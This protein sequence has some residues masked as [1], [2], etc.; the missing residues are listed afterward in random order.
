[1]KRSEAVKVTAIFV[2]GQTDKYHIL[3]P[4]TPEIWSPSLAASH[5]PMLC[6]AEV[7]RAELPERKITALTSLKMCG[8]CAR[9]LHLYPSLKEAVEG[10]LGRE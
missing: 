9:W 6:G 10:R 2:K 8:R 4:R 1:M 3:A 7:A 5:A